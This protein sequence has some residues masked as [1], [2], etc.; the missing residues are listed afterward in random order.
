M[1]NLLDHPRTSNRIS[2]SDVKEETPLEDICPLLLPF[3]FRP[4]QPSLD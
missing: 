1:Q 2:A 3:H 4:Y